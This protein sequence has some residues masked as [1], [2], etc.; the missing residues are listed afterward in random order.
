MA[1]ITVGRTLREKLLLILRKRSP[2]NTSELARATER[3]RTNV[4]L[5]LITAERAG[6]VT[7]AIERR[8]IQPAGSIMV[9]NYWITKEGEK[10]LKTQGIP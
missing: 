9:H 5:R 6:H 7:S 8:P 1:K 3:D 10:W 4:R 2:Q